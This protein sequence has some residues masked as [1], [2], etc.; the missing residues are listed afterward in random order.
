MYAIVGFLFFGLFIVFVIGMIQPRLILRWDNKPNRWKVF[1]FSVLAF[2]V[3]SILSVI[4]TPASTMNGNP[5]DE[6]VKINSL[7]SADRLK[8]EEIE[9]QEVDI[10]TE[11]KNKEKEQIESLQREIK[12]IKNGINFSSYRG[13]VSSLQMEL[14]LF[15]IWSKMVKK[16]LSSKNPEIKKL[17]A[18]LKSEAQ[19]IQNRE[20]PKM[21]ENYADV[22]AKLMWEN[23]IYITATGNRNQFINITGGLFSANKNKLD[24]QNKVFKILE[25]FRFKQSR[26]RWYKGA[27]K[28]TYWT[29]YKGNDSKPVAFE[30]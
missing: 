8:S 10:E 9:F 4:I 29:V 28:Y 24:F 16:G 6:I 20:F 17:S 7:K 26:Y 12:S 11:A 2:V 13:S 23:D 18:Q 22:A 3:I 30:E 5:K 15:S 25:M 27:D 14:V 21:R 1:G 19:N